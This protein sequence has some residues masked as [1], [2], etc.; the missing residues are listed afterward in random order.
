MLYL[1]INQNDDSF[2]NIYSIIAVSFV[3]LKF[4][5]ILN[6]EKSADVGFYIVAYLKYI[7]HQNSKKFKKD[8]VWRIV[9]SRTLILQFHLKN[10]TSIFLD[11]NH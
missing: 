6:L 2:L 5:K 1:K 10:V 11:I 8:G 7:Y 3:L 4:L 9:T